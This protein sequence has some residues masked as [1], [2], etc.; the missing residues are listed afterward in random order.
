MS[1]SF[2]EVIQL[3]NRMVWLLGRMLWGKE[4]GVFIGKGNT[5]MV[6]LRAPGWQDGLGLWG[7]VC[8]AYDYSEIF[9]PI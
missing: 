4:M 6:V 8:F 1:F 9:G 3:M 5:G 7:L 2:L